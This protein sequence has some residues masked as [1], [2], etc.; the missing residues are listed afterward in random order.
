MDRLLLPRT[1]LRKATAVQLSPGGASGLCLIVGMIG[2]RCQAAIVAHEPQ[3]VG[4]RCRTLCDADIAG[5]LPERPGIRAL[6]ITISP[7]PG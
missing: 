5:I 4:N 1:G 2:Q 3:P 7:G 6:G